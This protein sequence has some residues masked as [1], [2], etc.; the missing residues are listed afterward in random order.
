MLPVELVSRL[1]KAMCP[2]KVCLE[3]GEPS[4]RIVKRQAVWAATGEP[5]PGGGRHDGIAGIGATGFGGSSAT[6]SIVLSECWTDCGHNNWRQ[7][8][9]WYYTDNGEDEMT[10]KYLVAD[11]FDGLATLDDGSVDLVVTSPP[12]LALRSYLPADDPLKSKEIGSEPTPAAF[13]DVM[14]RFTA[15]LRRVVAPH[16]SIC[17]ELGDTYAGS[18]GSGG[19]YDPGGG[20]KGRRLLR[21]RVSGSSTPNMSGLS[22]ATMQQ[23]SRIFTARSRAAGSVGRSP[24]RKPSSLSSTGLL[25]PTGSTR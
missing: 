9:V 6:A 16:G 20:E 2:E 1:V 18:G 23:V 8:K 13:L 3:C 4:R 10:A 21:V 14:L 17:I 7:G 12:F 22:T 5:S 19:D 25:S 24:S 11:V 15:E